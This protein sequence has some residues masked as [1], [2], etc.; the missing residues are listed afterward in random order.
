[1]A[2]IGSIT[3]LLDL[4]TEMLGHIVGD[5][6]FRDAKNFGKTCRTAQQ[7][8]KNFVSDWAIEETIPAL[9]RQK[10]FSLGS[11]PEVYR[12]NKQFVCAALRIDVNNFSAIDETLQRDTK[13]LKTGAVAQLIFGKG[14][15]ASIEQ[16]L[17]ETGGEQFLNNLRDLPPYQYPSDTET[18]ENYGLGIFFSRGSG[19]F[20][21]DKEVLYGSLLHST[22]V[23]LRHLQRTNSKL[24]NDRDFMS[25]AMRINM[26]FTLK[27][28]HNVDSKFLRDCD[29]MFKAIRC[30]CTLTTETMD[31][32]LDTEKRE[33]LSSMILCSSHFNV[34]QSPL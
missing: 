31:A 23:V 3:T 18:W 8:F 2:S 5:L 27:H 25:E 26:F 34:M 21:D 20:R 13:V 17:N 14:I 12:R 6:A 30:C 4:P 29:F 19:V 28:L 33:G 9:L 15:D 16:K 32:L 1:M 11:M 10:T 7:A 24:L 22:S